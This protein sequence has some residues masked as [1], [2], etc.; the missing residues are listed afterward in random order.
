M[1]FVVE[2]CRLPPVRQRWLGRRR[3]TFAEDFRAK[4]PAFD[5]SDKTASVSLTMN[6]N[7]CEKALSKCV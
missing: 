5:K 3:M 4:R 6:Q 2:N 1:L 7:G